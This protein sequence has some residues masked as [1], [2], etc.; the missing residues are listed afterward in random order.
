MLPG[1]LEQ[2]PAVFGLCFHFGFDALPS[3][4]QRLQLLQSAISEE[5]DQA[6]TQPV[7]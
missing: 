7:K 3:L 2:S 4:F 6:Q 1:S 5:G